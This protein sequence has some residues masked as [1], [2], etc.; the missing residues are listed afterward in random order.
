MRTDSDR[1][2][3]ITADHQGHPEVPDR[4]VA[5]EMVERA[6]PITAS[7]GTIPLFC[8]TSPKFMQCWR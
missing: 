3:S 8:K 6:L 2:A 4:R 1:V 7:G 5:A